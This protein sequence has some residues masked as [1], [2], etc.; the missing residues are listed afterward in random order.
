[1]ST[2]EP[3]RPR[4]VNLRT[5]RDLDE[6]QRREHPDPADLAAARAARGLLDGWHAALADA[7]AKGLRAHPTDPD[8]AAAR[9]AEAL[10]AALPAAVESAAAALDTAALARIDAALAARRRTTP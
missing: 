8:Q 1:M 4:P 10:I 6:P 9:A 5:G 2:S 3:P 7:I